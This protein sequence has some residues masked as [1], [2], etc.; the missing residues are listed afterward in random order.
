MA[1]SPYTYK[2]VTEDLVRLSA[3][4]ESLSG[5]SLDG[6]GASAHSHWE[7]PQPDVSALVGVSH[8]SC[9]ICGKREDREEE[10]EEVVALKGQGQRV[11]GAGGGGGIASDM[12]VIAVRDPR[13]PSTALAEDAVRRYKVTRAFSP[14]TPQER[15]YE[16]Q[17]KLVTDWVWRGFN[18]TLVSFGQQGTGKSY[19]LY[20]DGLSLSFPQDRGLAAESGVDESCGLLIRILAD[21]FSR[22]A[23][24]RREDGGG[25]PKYKVGLSCWEI[26]G[27]KT[28]D[29]LKPFSAY[30]SPSRQDRAAQDAEYAT[31]GV[32]DLSQARA[33]LNHA[34]SSSTNWYVDP[35]TQSLR[36]LP[37]R[38]HAFVRVVVFDVVRRTLAQLHVVDLCG[39]QSL[40]KARDGGLG[41][42]EGRGAVPRDMLSEH[43]RER[44]GVNQQ[45][46][47]FSRLVGEIAQQS[48]D[49]EFTGG[50]AGQGQLSAVHLSARETKLTRELAPMLAEDSRCFLLCSVSRSSV[51]YIDTANTLRVATRFARISNACSKR[52]LSVDPLTFGFQ[53]I[54]SI[55]SVQ[56]QANPLKGSSELSGGGDDHLGRE[57]EFLRGSPLKVPKNL[58]EAK[59]FGRGGDKAKRRSKSKAT[60]EVIHL[61]L[62][63]VE[64]IEQVANEIM[65][66]TKQVDEAMAY[67]PAVPAGGQVSQSSKDDEEQLE[68]GGSYYSTAFPAR[69]VSTYQDP[70]L[71][72]AVKFMHSSSS[73]SSGTYGVAGRALPNDG[74]EHSSGVSMPV[75][76]YAFSHGSGASHVLND[77]AKEAAM[78]RLKELKGEV[79]MK[80]GITL[81][82][83]SPISSDDTG[84]SS[85][86]RA[87]ASPSPSVSVVSSV[88]SVE[89]QRKLDSLKQNFRSMYSEL[90]LPSE[91]IEQDDREE[92]SNENDEEVGVEAG[93]E[94]R[95]PQASKAEPAEDITRQRQSP[96]SSAMLAEASPSNARSDTH[97]PSLGAHRREEAAREERPPAAADQVRPSMGLYGGRY[98][99]EQEMPSSTGDELRD[100]LRDEQSSKPSQRDYAELERAYDSLLKM[101]EREREA[102]VSSQQKVKLLERDLLEVQHT[103]SAELDGQKLDNVHLRS[104]CRQLEELVGFSPGGQDVE[105]AEIYQEFAQGGDL[106]PHIGRR[107]NGGLLGEIFVQLE[108]E[109]DRVN[110]ENALLREDLKSAHLSHAETV[111][112]V[113]QKIEDLDVDPTDSDVDS[114][115]EAEAGRKGS[116]DEGER[117]DGE[118]R[119]VLREYR[120]EQ[121]ELL[122]RHQ[123]NKLQA[124]NKRMKKLEEDLQETRVELA[125]YRK[126]DRKYAIQKRGIEETI[127]RVGQLQKQLEQKNQELVRCQLKF[128]E[129]EG[130]SYTLSEEHA[131]MVQSVQ[132]MQE[133]V[134]HSET[135]KRKYAEQLQWA[136]KQ[137]NRDE[138]L[139]K[140]PP[141]PSGASEM[142]GGRLNSLATRKIHSTA[143]EIC[144]RIRREPGLSP[145]VENMLDRLMEEVGLHVQE[146]VVL[147]RREALLLQMITGEH[148]GMGGLRRRK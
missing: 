129:S 16:D 39:S 56:E 141:L 96:E 6:Q 143:G 73:S 48:D 108:D 123:K 135:V 8:V 115:G 58:P 46:L 105:M 120:R 44:K 54:D 7:E 27:N 23:K 107:R 122:S 35:A 59:D 28:V 102:H 5:R 110:E 47:A 125:A 144:R 50:R 24:E 119:D 97:S 137:V 127:K 134:D 51:D 116:D 131:K 111:A 130:R 140:L 53:A 95:F 83:R 1:G 145:R 92:S 148:R 57:D 14:W 85:H 13:A 38:A 26:L 86:D 40:A 3:E 142:D 32:E 21:L 94:D 98:E 90:E 79:G 112:L 41:K 84:H 106:A 88:K 114:D 113:H 80:E 117:L 49:R 45:L 65:E 33:C 22:I 136:R 11:L 31:I 71:S 139:S 64:N 100:G 12:D 118:T 103:L 87:S 36:T 128:A 61:T 62:S 101:V 37:N 15:V 69:D 72:G 74:E 68:G 124:L 147:A 70:I 17:G 99:F 10:K 30:A 138:V 82:I 2:P 19:T 52:V 109:V 4:I 81:S 20:N 75:E 55:L 93:Q 29:L 34:R 9:R 126:K 60:A 89:T 78:A 63:Q 133:K 132:K 121:K 25:R 146:R 67:S 42:R 77:A 104:R 66:T 18:A 91:A 76:R 43:E